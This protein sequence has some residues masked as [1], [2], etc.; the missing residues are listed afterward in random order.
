MFDP[1]LLRERARRCRELVKIAAVPEVAEQLKIWA[2]DFDEEASKLDEE[3]AAAR[4][5]LHHSMKNR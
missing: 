3:L 1:D 2:R 5:A 4:R